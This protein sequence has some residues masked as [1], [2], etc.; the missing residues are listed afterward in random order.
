VL[1]YSVDRELKPK[2]EYL[3]SVCLYPTFELSSFPAYFSYPL[4]RVI[5][6]RYEYLQYVKKAPT[7]LLA[8]DTVVRY[9][10]KDFAERVAKDTDGGVAF[11][12]FAKL[13]RAARSEQTGPKPKDKKDS[14]TLPRSKTQRP[15][16]SKLK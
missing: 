15:K 14:K 6:T 9:G 1:G 16:G 7:Q 2:W 13:R 10:D 5:K 3:S 8:L 12:K 11:A 4:D